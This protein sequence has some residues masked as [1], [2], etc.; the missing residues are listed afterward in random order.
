ML[1]HGYLPGTDPRVP[2]TLFIQDTC[3]LYCVF[4]VEL[5][6]SEF[7][8]SLVVYTV[9]LKKA[10]VCTSV[11]VVR[12]VCVWVESAFAICYG[13]SRVRVFRERVLDERNDVGLTPSI[14]FRFLFEFYLSGIEFLVE[15]GND[16]KLD[17]LHLLCVCFIVGLLCRCLYLGQ[18]RLL[19]AF[20]RLF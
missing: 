12:I 4:R 18:N 13:D 3:K 14:Y 10:T 11:C 9:Q 1:V 16:F 20:Y 15:L 2:V 17:H 7:L 8:E 6:E 19:L 5:V